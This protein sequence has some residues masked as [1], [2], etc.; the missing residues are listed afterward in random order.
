MLIQTPTVMS[1]FDRFLSQILHLVPEFPS[2]LQDSGDIMTISKF[3]LPED[4]MNWSH[5]TYRS[6]VLCDNYRYKMEHY[7]H[8][9]LI[10]FFFFCISTTINQS[11]FI[12]ENLQLI[13]VSFKVCAS[14]L[15]NIS[16]N[17]EA[18]Q[19]ENK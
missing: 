14:A 16:L 10:T 13:Y 8:L 17:T 18:Q 12:P 4:E 6:Y 11:E 1:H 7:S 2:V 19:Q 5:T 3:I 9:I 15:L